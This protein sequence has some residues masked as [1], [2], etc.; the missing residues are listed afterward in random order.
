MKTRSTA[1]A[2]SFDEI[3]ENVSCRETLA[4]TLKTDGSQTK[5]MFG[6][7]FFFFHFSQTIE[8]ND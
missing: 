3:C 4:E 1:N 8:G 2:A 7:F 6:V 5:E